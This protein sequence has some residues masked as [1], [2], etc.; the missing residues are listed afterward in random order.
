MAKYQPLN[1]ADVFSPPLLSITKSGAFWFPFIA[2][3]LLPA[4]PVT[5]V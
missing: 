5:N 1:K 4:F 2:E 3:L